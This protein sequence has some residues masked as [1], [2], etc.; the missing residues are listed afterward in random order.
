MLTCKHFYHMIFMKHSIH[1]IIFAQD[2][3][4]HFPYVLSRKC[5]YRWVGPIN[6]SRQRSLWW[7]ETDYI[8]H[9]T[10]DSHLLLVK[11]YFV[12]SQFRIK[13][14]RFSFAFHTYI[15]FYTTISEFYCFRTFSAPNFFKT[16]YPKFFP[17]A[18]QQPV[19]LFTIH[20]QPINPKNQRKVLSPPNKVSIF[21]YL[22][23]DWATHR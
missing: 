13:S 10:R 15:Q 20:Q 11:F 8:R 12:L 6:L 17:H 16:P 9:C 23:K 5:T 14:A 1:I 7:S 3:L 18:Q 19:H 21:K 22:S 2:T 4:H